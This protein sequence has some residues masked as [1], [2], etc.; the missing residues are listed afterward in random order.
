MFSGG[1]SPNG[2]RIPG[3]GRMPNAPRIRG[4]GRS[5]NAPRIRG[6]GRSLNAPTKCQ[7]FLAGDRQM[8][9]GYQGLGECQMP[10]GLGECHSPLRN[11]NVFW[12]MPFAP[13]ECQRFLAIAKCPTDTRVWGI[14]ANAICPRRAGSAYAP[15]DTKECQGLGDRQMPPRIPMFSGDSQT[16]YGYQRMPFADKS[17]RLT[18]QLLKVF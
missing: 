11:A 18:C 7:R 10:Q 8:P 2:L 3:S 17:D 5:P 15:T 6:S 16:P 9:H 1:R 12:R 4:S 13:T 14:W